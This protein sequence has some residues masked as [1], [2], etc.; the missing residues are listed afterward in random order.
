MPRPI[1]ILSLEEAHEPRIFPVEEETGL[2]LVEQV[3]PITAALRVL[4]NVAAFLQTL[5]H[6]SNAEVVVGIFQRAG[7]RSR[8]GAEAFIVKVLGWDVAQGFPAV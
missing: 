6:L 1:Q 2:I 5:G 3:L 8:H 7:Y 4:I